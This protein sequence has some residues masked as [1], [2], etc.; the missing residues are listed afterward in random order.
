LF[1]RFPKQD[2]LLKM[3]G[4]VCVVMAIFSM[5]LFVGM[6]SDLCMGDNCTP[7]FVYAAVPA[8]VFFIATAVL[9][10]L[11]QRANPEPKS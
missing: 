5:V 10:F 1:F 3:I 2:L 6:A 4:V 8:F 9:L 7:R 11:F